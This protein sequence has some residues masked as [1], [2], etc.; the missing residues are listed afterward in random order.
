[1]INLRLRSKANSRFRALRWAPL[2][3]LL[4]TC[5]LIVCLH[6]RV[7]AATAR[8]YK[9]KAA[10]I[11]NFV[12]FIEWPAQAV[13]DTIT[14]CV[15]GQEAYDA[16]Y[17]TLNG[18]SVVG[19]TVVVR[20]FT[21]VRDLRGCQILF[22]SGD[23]RNRWRQIQEAIENSPV[24]TVGEAEGFASGGGVIN[25][26]TQSNKLRFE[27][28]PDAAERAGLRISSQLLRLSR[29]PQAKR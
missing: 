6:T 2:C 16:A 3:T 1:M 21:G 15:L 25:F 27:I 19:R 12:K 4:F 26:Y 13:R 11:Y 28:N 20:P 24:L 10:C 29:V 9:I 23:E 17:S 22:I 18:K 14:V 7:Q 5:F 8:E